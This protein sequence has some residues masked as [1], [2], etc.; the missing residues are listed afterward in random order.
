MLDRQQLIEGNVRLV[1]S[2][3]KRFVGRGI[4]YDDIFQVGCVGL[5]KAADGFDETRGLCFST[6]AV[7]TILGE[8]KRLF[9][10]T[11]AI[12]VSRSLKELSL[13]VQREKEL[14]EKSGGRADVS[15]I[16]KRLGVA[17]EDVAEAVAASR[18]VVSLTFENDDGINEIELPSESHEN[19]VCAK[20][21]VNDAISKLNKQEQD[22]IRLRYFCEKTQTESAKLLGISQV[23]VSRKE[24]RALEK[25]RLYMR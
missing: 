11:G 23:Q 25:L 18:Q 4:E 21:L 17:E 15:E 3:C 1:H 14:I 13:K 20:I 5:V 24:K 7:P 22:I 12:K 19:E 9:R 16:A 8:I 2:C 6:Y 10:D